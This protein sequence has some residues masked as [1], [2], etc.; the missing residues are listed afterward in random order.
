[1]HIKLASESDASELIDYYVRNTEHFRRWEPSRSD[2][3]E[4]ME[5]WVDKLQEREGEIRQGKAAY[6]IGIDK[7]SNRIIGHCSLTSIVYG[8]FMATYMGYAVDREF[9]GKGNMK[10][11]CYHA[12]DH[13]FNKLGLH[14]IMANYMPSNKR[15]GKLLNRLGFVVEGEAKKYLKINDKWEN[16]VL[17]S[18]INSR[19]M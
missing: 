16:H 8:A 13:A 19:K 15:S 17:T 10:V 6:F 2:D 11:L 12:I 7:Q 5:S 3:F 18:L 1:M 9:E 14:R 4:C